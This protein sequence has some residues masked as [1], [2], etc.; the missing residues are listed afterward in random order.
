MFNSNFVKLKNSKIYHYIQ[1]FIHFYIH[2]HNFLLSIKLI[3]DLG[4]EIISFSQIK[5]TLKKPY[6]MSNFNLYK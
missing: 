1:F 4:I 6:N 3:K 2:Y 5:H